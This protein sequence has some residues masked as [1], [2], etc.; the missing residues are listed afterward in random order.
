M[1]DAL[2]MLPDE[3]RIP[4]LVTPVEVDAQE[5]DWGDAVPFS[6]MAWFAGEN[7]LGCGYPQSKPSP[8]DGGDENGS[9]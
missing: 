5:T 2:N 6:R 4:L 7:G 1:W 9:Q 8:P 3:E